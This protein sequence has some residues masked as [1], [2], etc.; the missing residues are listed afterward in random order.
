M[1]RGR[2]TVRERAAR[3]MTARKYGATRDE[4][5]VIRDLSEEDYKLAIAGLKNHKNW[6]FY[7]DK[8]IVPIH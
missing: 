6:R 2:L 1:P 3:Y 8:E 7:F 4:A 5:I